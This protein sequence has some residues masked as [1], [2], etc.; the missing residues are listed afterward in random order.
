MVR[1]SD[2]S[3]RRS[4]RRLS[5]SADNNLVGIRRRRQD[6]PRG[7][8]CRRQDP[9]ALTGH[10]QAGHVGQPAT[11]TPRSSPAAR[12]SWSVWDLKLARWPT[13]RRSHAGVTAVAFAPDQK[14]ILSAGADNQL[15]VN[16]YS[17]QRMHPADEKGLKDFAVS[18]NGAFYGTTHPDATVKIWDVNNGNM[19]RPFTGLKAQHWR[20]RFI[21]TISSSRP[22]GATRTSAL[23]NVNDAAVQWKLPTPAE[24]HPPVQRRWQAAAGHRERPDDPSL[25]PRS[26]AAVAEPGAA[27]GADAAD[28]DGGGRHGRGLP[29]N[30]QDAA[31]HF[32]R[33]KAAAVAGLGR[34]GARAGRDTSRRS[35]AS[36]SIPTARSSPGP[37]TTRR[38][39]CGT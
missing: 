13:V 39:S 14:T 24:V 18:Q 32:R 36:P 29:A 23:W 6:R 5:V 4:R 34:A 33:W 22:A 31:G 11:T 30:K 2:R 8:D 27:A 20:S 10:A 12:I 9:A 26:A 1:P 37:P 15:Y 7:T 17:L 3:T 38:S 25:Q 35:I 16:G 19:V 21:R 28:Q